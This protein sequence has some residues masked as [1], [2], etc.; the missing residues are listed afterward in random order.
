MEV[1]GTGSGQER[2]EMWDTEMAADP[3]L[4][5]GST[6]RPWQGKTVGW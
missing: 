6:W 3:S 1:K 2:G 4:P 5:P